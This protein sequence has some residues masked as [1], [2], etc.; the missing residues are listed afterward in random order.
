[1]E[2]IQKTIRGVSLPAMLG[3]LLSGCSYIENV[4]LSSNGPTMDPTKIYMTNDY[5]SVSRQS[6]LDKY[7]CLSG[8]LQCQAFGASL[9]C[10]CSGF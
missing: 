8:P 10:V 2:I 7:V 4:I 3:M 6:D 9:D 1:M 5:F